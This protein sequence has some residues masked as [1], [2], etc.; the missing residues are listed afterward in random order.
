MVRAFAYG[1]QIIAYVLFALFIGYF[2]SRPAYTHFDPQNAQVKLSFS[3]AGARKEECRRLTQE[4]LNELPPNMRQPTDCPRERV[5]LVVDIQMNGERLYRASLPPSGLWG[6]GAS[7][8]YQRFAVQPG[9]HQVTAR[10]RDSRRQEGFDY[11]KTET[12]TVKAGMN[13]V[14]DFR[15]DQGG[16]IFH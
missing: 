2:S 10:L 9:Q 3:H 12:I 16:F 7:T 1:G 4:E 11:V 14:I 15:A 5:S 6:D 13:F 8:V